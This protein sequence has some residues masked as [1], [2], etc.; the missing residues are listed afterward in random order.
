M[1]DAVNKLQPKL[2]VFF[3]TCETWI[4]E[5]LT[6]IRSEQIQEFREKYRRIDMLL[7]DDVQVLNGRPITQQELADRI[8]SL[9]LEGSRVALGHS[10]RLSAI[11]FLFP[12]DAENPSSEKALVLEMSAPTTEEMIILR[13]KLATKYSNISL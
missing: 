10:G 1:H 12:A 8:A 6:A 13:M 3:I 9:L 4:D 11:P 5:F 7:I 2:Q